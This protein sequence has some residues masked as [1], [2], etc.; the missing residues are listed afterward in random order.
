MNE[1]KFCPFCDNPQSPEQLPGGAGKYFGLE[2][3]FFPKIQP[4]KKKNVWDIMEFCPLKVADRPQNADF[5]PILGPVSDFEGTELPVADAGRGLKSAFSVKPSAQ[6][7]GHNSQ[8]W[9]RDLQE[10]LVTLEVFS[11]INN[12]GFFSPSLTIPRF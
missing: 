8:G 4:E 5:K 1:V 9:N 3:A 6:T 7:P 10:D 12:S 11:D 2:F